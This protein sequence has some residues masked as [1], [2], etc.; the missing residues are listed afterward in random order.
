MVVLLDNLALRVLSTVPSL[1]RSYVVLYSQSTWK[2]WKLRIALCITSGKGG[3]VAEA[4]GEDWTSRLRIN[5]NITNTY[6]TCESPHQATRFHGK[7][8]LHNVSSRPEVIRIRIQTSEAKLD[9][10]RL[11]QFPAGRAGHRRP[12]D[13]I[14]N[15]P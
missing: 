5:K 1:K 6:R 4:N 3:A 12:A 9:I 11:H 10:F 8:T 14:S 2:R 13:C 7:A 15:P